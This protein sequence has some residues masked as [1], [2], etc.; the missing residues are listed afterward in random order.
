MEAKRVDPRSIH[1]PEIRVTAQ[2]DEELYKQFQ[3]SIKAVG[4]IAPVICY[5]VDGEV[6]G[7]DGKHRCDE[8][9][10]N[11]EELV[12]IVL[13]PGDM[14]D[15]LTKNIFLDH[16]RGNTPPSEMVTVITTLYNEYGLDP[17]QLEAKTG[18]TR[19][20]IEKL[21]KIGLASPSVQEA[22]DKG[23][24]T[25]GH[26]A[27]LAR[28]PHPIQ[29]DE[30]IAKHQVWRFTVK[31]LK[32]QVDAVLSEM[33]LLDKAAPLPAPT[34]PPTPRKYNCEGCRTEAE[35][36]YLRPVML[37]PDCFGSVWRLAKTAPAPSVDAKDNGEGA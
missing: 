17:D 12:D 14:V 24:I 31:D 8:A 7:C 29:Q 34:D 21:I 20:Y 10:M 25:V 2:F 32:D 28:L 30:V 9:I 6:V 35:P 36:R 37:C 4:Q 27:E 22:L 16:L 26:A 23:V 13:I 3:D 33:E 18:L 5:N 1:W 11:G 19:N 15:V